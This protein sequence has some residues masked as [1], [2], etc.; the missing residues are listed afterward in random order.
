[1]Q[2]Q[3]AHETLVRRIRTSVATELTARTRAAEVSGTRRLQPDDEAMLAR[4][5]VN[6]HLDRLA[7][8][9]LVNG[10]GLLDD[11][12]EAAIA[13]AVFDRLFQLGRLQPLLDDDRIQNII[14][15]GCDQ[16]F[17]EYADGTKVAG[18]P[19][20]DTD[21]ELIDTLREIGR[22]YGLS[23]REFNP[24]RP[25]AQPATPRRQPPVRRRVGLRPARASRSAATAS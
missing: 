19:I 23:E 17:I 20:A 4:H 3:D 5:L 6:E 24:G 1:M 14:A 15:N 9:A 21:D 11:K 10:H 22:R 25:S 12:T 13:R 7:Q 2:T 16:V 18:P 8:D